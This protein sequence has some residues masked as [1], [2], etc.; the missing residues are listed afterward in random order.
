MKNILNRKDYNEFMLTERL[1]NIDE[2][3]EILYDAY[4]KKDIEKLRSPGTLPTNLFKYSEI[5]TSY[6]TT[7][8]A[9]KAHKENPCKIK[10]NKGSNHYSPLESI[11]S[12]SVS[13]D[14]YWFT[15][16]EHDGSLRK[17]YKYLSKNIPTQAKNF[18]NEFNPSK[19]KGSIHHELTHWI[20]DTLHNKHIKKRAIISTETGTDMTK[21]GLP[22]NADKLEIEGQIHN[23]Y[24]LKKEFSQIWDNLSFDDLIKLSTT[25]SVVNKELKG[26]INKQWR[27][28]LKKRMWREGLFGKNMA[29]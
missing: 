25:L 21:K 16:N 23:I 22:I 6:L 29:N 10:I 7:P 26:D 11:I 3:V 4:F 28:N 15:I 9:K 20:D 8:L 14:A 18:I 2:D 19:I 13:L 12:I 24:Q 1:M 17:A 5:D 27:K